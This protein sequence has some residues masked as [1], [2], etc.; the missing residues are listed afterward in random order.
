MGGI[1]L[2][3]HPLVF[4]FAFYFAITGRI[5]VFVVYTVSAVIHELGHA[6][7]SARLG[8]KLGK[9]TLMPFG[10][11]ISGNSSDFRPTDEIKIALA[12]P[13]LNLAVGLFFVAVWWFFPET[14]AFTD[15]AAEA[16][17]S[18]AIVNFIPCYPL[19]GGRVLLASLSMIWNRK[20]AVLLCKTL[21]VTLA[22]LF[23]ALFVFSCFYTI[24]FTLLFFSLFMFCGALS[25]DTEN[26]YVR[27]M[28]SL[29]MDKLK[30]GVPI[31]RH[32]I[33]KDTTIKMLLRLLDYRY[34]NE[35]VVFNGT[36]KIAELSENDLANIVNSADLY[37]PIDKYLYKRRYNA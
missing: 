29:S 18:L 19:D 28:P 26:T 9:I 16:S 10:A 22:I 11:V 2:K 5:W 24:N 27:I 31:K 6:F 7:S 1:K 4:P 20:K 35:V 15:V 13:L 12:G 37:A 3:I 21:G 23:F 33:S 17:F 32:A 30:T 25:K 14:Y 34:V 36:E 8:Y